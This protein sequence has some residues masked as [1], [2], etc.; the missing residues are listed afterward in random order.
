MKRMIA[1]LAVL[2][3][4]CAAVPVLADD[5]TDNPFNMGPGST[6]LRS[7]AHNCPNTGIMLPEVF[8][9]Y[10]TTYLLT[11]AS[12]VSRVKFT[13]VAM[14]AAAVITVNGQAVSSGAESQIIQMTD[15]P[16]EVQIQVTNGN[17]STLYTVYLQRRPSEKRTQVG[18]AL[19]SEIFLDKTTWKMAI[20]RVDIKWRG[21]DY[22]S[23]NLST[24]T[25]P[26]VK[27]RD[28]VDEVDPHCVLYYGT[29][30]NP[31]RAENIEIFRQHYLDY[32]SNLYTIIHIED[33]IV[34]VLPYGADY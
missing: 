11:V 5:G 23:G 4:L 15:K 29:K 16:Q 30:A 12:W 25:N 14:D 8:S 31:V 33:V 13:P 26:N 19:I 2:A 18:A 6:M 22:Q 10:Q 7:L 34:A 32:G 17:S 21:N 1:L 20:D 3:L 28:R 24:F 9:P 27:P